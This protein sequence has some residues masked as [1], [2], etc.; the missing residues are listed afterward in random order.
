MS[1][2][3]ILKGRACYLALLVTWTQ[4]PRRL[5]QH[6]LQLL[7]PPVAPQEQQQATDHAILL[8]TILLADCK[9]S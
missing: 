5:R 7:A 6:H 1:K 3:T 9:N 8:C 2:R 4:V